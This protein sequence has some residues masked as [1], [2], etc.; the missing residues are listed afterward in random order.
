MSII[1]RMPP[2]FGVFFRDALFLLLGMN[3]NMPRHVL[4]FEFLVR[5]EGCGIS[6]VN[7]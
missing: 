7:Q 1:V 2:F 5:K 3:A 4:H 6:I